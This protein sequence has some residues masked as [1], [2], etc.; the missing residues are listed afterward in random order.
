MIITRGEELPHCHHCKRSKRGGLRHSAKSTPV[1]AFLRSVERLAPA[2]DD[3]LGG[4][5]KA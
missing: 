2:P 4:R 3:H 5:E 1:I